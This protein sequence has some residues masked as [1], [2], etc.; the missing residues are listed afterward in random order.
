LHGS[1]RRYRHVSRAVSLR[2]MRA[3]GQLFVGA[4]WRLTARADGET[5]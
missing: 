5:N 3:A 2:E 1:V 4:E